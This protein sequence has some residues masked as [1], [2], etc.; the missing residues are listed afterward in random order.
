MNTA[1]LTNIMINTLNALNCYLENTDTQE[2]L[3]KRLYLKL[4]ESQLK[5]RQG[6]IYM[7]SHVAQASML[8]LKRKDSLIRILKSSYEN[9]HNQTFTQQSQNQ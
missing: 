5:F 4:F 1:N 3:V 2:L 9:I 8:Q 6:T 7:L